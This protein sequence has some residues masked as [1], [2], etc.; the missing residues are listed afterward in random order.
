MA[1][2]PTGTCARL[3]RE[4]LGAARQYL[5]EHPESVAA[6]NALRELER[7]EKQRNALLRLGRRGADRDGTTKTRC[8]PGGGS[9]RCPTKRELR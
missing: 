5:L 6:T 3:M 8:Y 7:E 9:R 2:D 1:S 4:G